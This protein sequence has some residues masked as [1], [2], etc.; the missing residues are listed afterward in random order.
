MSKDHG[1]GAG[2]ELKG[3]VKEAAG[4]A[5]GS[6][7]TENEGKTDKAKGRAQ[8]TLGDVKDAFKKK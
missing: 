7:R 8:Q 2:K 4:K 6:K 1:K 3:A 5:T